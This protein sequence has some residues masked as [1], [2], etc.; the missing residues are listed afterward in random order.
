MLLGRHHVSCRAIDGR[1]AFFIRTIFVVLIFSEAC[2]LLRLELQM[3]H[4]DDVDGRSV[5][6]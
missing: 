5:R 6:G 3:V 1:S 4:L 2:L